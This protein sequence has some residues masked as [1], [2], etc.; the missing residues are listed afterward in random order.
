MPP[1]VL[2]FCNI[3]MR[4]GNPIDLLIPLLSDPPNL[5]VLQDQQNW[6]TIKRHAGRYGVAPLVAHA[7]RLHVS[8]SERLWCDQ[9]LIDS[10]KHS[11]RML[12]DLECLLNLF[13]GERIPTIT[14]KGPLLAQRYYTPAVLRR[15][16]MD[17]DLAV[18]EQDLGRACD[19]LIGAGYKL[20]TSIGEALAQSHHVRLTHP[21]RPRVELHFRL[22]HLTLGIPVGEF[23]E[24]A[25]SYRLP[26]GQEALVLSPADQLLHLM[27]HFAHNRFGTLFHLYEIRRVSAAEPPAVLR[28]AIQSAVDHHFCGVL[29]MIDIAFR[30]RWDER[31]LPLDVKVPRTWLDWRLNE[32][33]YEAFERWWAP[34]RALTLAARLRGRW[35][36]FQIT[37]SA[38]DAFRSIMLLTRTARFQIAGRGWI[39]ARNLPGG[40]DY[41][42][43]PTLPR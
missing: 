11:E 33:L 21:S 13:A 2:V 8:P 35:L 22:T 39:T 34:G 26:N 20:E 12:K 42:P 15:P 31:F 36:D 6:D 28:A 30:A 25:V 7:A 40:P 16:S 10:Q 24:R 4:P 18:M 14:L 41:S 29:R 1:S 23:F 43:R 37:D 19:A 17:H 3:S 27:L 38:A 9:I 32:K 5:S